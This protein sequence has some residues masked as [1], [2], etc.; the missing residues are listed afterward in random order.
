ME[1]AGVTLP[2][3]KLSVTISLTSIQ[4]QRHANLGLL[5][6]FFLRTVSLF[7]LWFSPLSP[8]PRVTVKKVGDRTPISKL[9]LSHSEDFWRESFSFEDFR[10][11]KSSPINGVITPSRG[12]VWRLWRLL[13]DL[14]SG[15]MC[16]KMESKK[17]DKGNNVSRNS[18]KSS[19][20]LII[21]DK[22][23]IWRH[24]SGLKQWRLWASKVFTKSSKVFTKSSKVFTK[25]SKGIK[26]FVLGT[27]F[28]TKSFVSLERL[29]QTEHKKWL[30]CIKI[31]TWTV[32]F[33]RRRISHRFGK[34]R[35]RWCSLKTKFILF[36][37]TFTIKKM[38]RLNLPSAHVLPTLGLPCWH[39]WCFAP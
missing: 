35:F 14:G 23:L 37:I 11:Q 25:S 24:L 13:G 27:K 15:S 8:F 38:L 22:S 2:S 18:S 32:L 36:M 30:E 16:R 17:K 26:S 5:P 34:E 10:V 39:F 19:S 7:W 3:N 33:L 9:R 6:I 31:R 4:S 1:S 12:G 28:L 29:E 21:W 20:Y